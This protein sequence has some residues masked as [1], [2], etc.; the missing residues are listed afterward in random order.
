MEKVSS[1]F[2]VAAYPPRR[3]GHPMTA[4]EIVRAVDWKDLK[5]LSLKEMLIENNI[6]LPWLLMSWLLAYSGWYLLA[7]PFSF[8]FFL[9]GLRQVHNGFHGALGTSKWLTWLCLYSNSLLMMTS[10]HAVK[11]NHLRHHKYCLGEEDHEG[12]CA[13]MKWYQAL[14]YGPVHIWMIHQITWQ[15]G[16]PAYRRDMVLEVLSLLLFAFSA[17]YFRIPFLMY[18]VLVMIAGECC[19]AFFAVWTVHHDTDEHDPAMAR[20][21]RSTWK[22]RITFSMFYHLEHHLFPAVATIKLPELARRI[23]KALPELNKKSTF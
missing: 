1:Q 19:S 5:R 9:T 8:F 15:K 2:M 18:H 11:F 23:D 14:F 7:L 20:T 22:N 16:G 10:G 17:F 21:Q 3:G 13:R 4:T 12:R 6:T